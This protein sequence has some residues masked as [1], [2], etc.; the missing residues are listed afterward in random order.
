MRDPAAAR[1]AW[2][3]VIARDGW[4]A[5]RA[6]A[7]AAEAGMALADLL[8]LAGD[9]VDVVSAL[10][11][12]VG[13]ESVAGAAGDGAPR[14]RLFDGIMRGLDV[15]Q[16]ERAAVLA[17]ADARDPGL[18][19]LVAAHAGQSARRLLC[20][21]GVGTTGPAGLVRQAGLLAILAR[22]FDVWRRDDSPDMAATMAELD[23]LMARAAAVAEG[24]I[25]R[26]LP[27]GPW[28]RDRATGEGPDPAAQ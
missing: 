17:L 1:R 15:L 25:S 5:A 19:A 21:A 18:V 2:L 12:Q 20:A 22:T 9:P 6:D 4:H 24:G 3:A 7:A 8:A 23:R 16:G 26:L 13:A 14:D 11:R 28:R 10:L 27:D